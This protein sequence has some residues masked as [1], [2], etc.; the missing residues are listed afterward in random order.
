MNGRRIFEI[1]ELFEQIKRIGNHSRSCTFKDMVVVGETKRGL[2]SI[3]KFQCKKCGVIRKIQSCPKKDNSLSCN[4]EAVLGISSI[5]SGFYHL[6]EFFTQLNVPVMG[7]TT[8]DK[9]QKQQ[10]TNWWKLA[11]QSALD[12]LYEEIEL[13]K[14]IGSVDSM[15]NALIAVIC[16]GGWGK[17][18]YGKAFNSLSGCA[19]LIGVRTKK[20]VYFDVRNKYCHT[21]KIAQSKCTPPNAHICNKNYTGPS[22]G[23]EADIILEGFKSS[24]Q[25]GARYFKLIADGDSSTYKALRDLRVY[26]NPDLFIEK[27][28]CVNHL[29]RNFRTRFNFLTK[30]T[31]FKVA[32]RKHIT[33]SKGQGICKG[34]KVAAKH[35]RESNLGMV[36]KISNLEDDI[37]NAPLHYFGVHDK[38]KSYFCQKVTD[39]G[40]VDNVN[41][42]KKDG[43]YYEVLN[44]C[45]TYF[46]GNAKSLLENNTNNAAEEFNNIVAKYLGGKR[47][48]Y[49]LGQSYTARVAIAVVQYNSG[50]HSGSEYRKFIF[51]NNHHTSIENLENSR[52]RKLIANEVARNVKPR[53]RRPAQELST[54]GTQG[55]YFHGCNT[56]TVD[57]EPAAYENAK[58]TFLAK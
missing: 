53:E 37:M 57:M 58:K 28:E 30:V 5:G 41:L 40:A 22:S 13:A 14:S 56:E 16:D 39:Q 50:G 33:P 7:S 29:Y 12:A 34:I 26:R 32:S 51:G 4:E 21:C 24:E 2:N 49:S 36:K 46:A 38:C 48:N 18:S 19:V 25:H 1:G 6:K 17:R 15:G 43:L 23:M 31:K 44:L 45:Q 52:K 42:L 9:I 27:C 20:V 35:W 47:I 10:Q 11:K 8:Y 54:K 55:A 3:F